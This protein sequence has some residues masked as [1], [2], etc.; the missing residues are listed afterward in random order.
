MDHSREV[1][2]LPNLLLALVV[3]AAV[4]F[5]AGVA[6][7]FVAGKLLYERDVDADTDLATWAQPAEP[8]DVHPTASAEGPS[9][10]EPLDRPRP[11]RARTL[12]R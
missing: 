3:I 5:L 11:R 9:P 12:Q 6:A 1:M 7:S 10:E 4:G 2:T 8:I